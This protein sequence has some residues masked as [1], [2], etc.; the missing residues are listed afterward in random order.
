MFPSLLR[1]F[2]YKWGTDS[3]PNTEINAS[4]VL[5]KMLLIKVSADAS[6]K[7]IGESI[8]HIFF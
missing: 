5:L 4:Q 8:C 7:G 6:R 3:V 1:I 2:G